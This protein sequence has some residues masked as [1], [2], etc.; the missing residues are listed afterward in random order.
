[1]DFKQ[2]DD[3]DVILIT[4]PDD[5]Q[6]PAVY[7]LYA[8]CF[9]HTKET[10]DNLRTVLS[11]NPDDQSHEISWLGLCDKQ[12]GQVM[13]GA[14]IA[15]YKNPDGRILTDNRQIPV[16]GT[17]HTI[18]IFVDPEQRGK[19]LFQKMLGEIEEYTGDVLR[20]RN[21]DVYHF[22]DQ[23]SPV[24]MTP[25]EWIE[26]VLY[27]GVDP[28]DRRHIFEKAGFAGAGAN[29]ILPPNDAADYYHDSYDVIVRN[30][31]AVPA[32]VVSQHMGNYINTTFP[33]L[34]TTANDP[35][36]A[37]MFEELRG[38]EEISA[39]PKGHHKDQIKPAIEAVIGITSQEILA[40]APTTITDAYVVQQVAHYKEKLGAESFSL[41]LGTNKPVQPAANTYYLAGGVSFDEWADRMAARD[42]QH[43]QK[44]ELSNWKD[45]RAQQQ[46]AKPSKTFGMT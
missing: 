5:P 28:S 42:Q 29:L 27:S 32:P 24:K 30:R 2:K 1:M 45:R 46:S 11:R 26:D 41:P 12:T 34:A 10:A 39:L 43:Q 7:D 9:G 23:F 4:N 31:D 36:L 17:E 25:G 22:A 14:N 38:R 44:A 18:Y 19:K 3:Y 21:D 13:A 40:N 8:Q 35:L 20:P 33:D 37:P 16:S 6:F 15:L